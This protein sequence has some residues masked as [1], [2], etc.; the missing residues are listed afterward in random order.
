ME[1]SW[2]SRN[3]RPHLSRLLKMLVFGLS[4]TRGPYGPHGIVINVA[5]ELTLPGMALPC[6]WVMKCVCYLI[7]L[8]NLLN[9]M[10]HAS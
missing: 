7:L 10:L 3:P 5:L 2:P 6:D 4:P 1:Q 9:L 8:Y